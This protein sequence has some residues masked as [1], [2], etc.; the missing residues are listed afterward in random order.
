M[1]RARFVSLIGRESRF[2]AGLDGGAISSYSRDYDHPSRGASSLTLA[3]AEQS[4]LERQRAAY[5]DRIAPSISRHNA[6]LLRALFVHNLDQAEVAALQGCTRQ[7][8][9]QRLAILRRRFSKVNDWWRARLRAASPP[10]PRACV[11]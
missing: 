10:G 4:E 1:A 7:A 5:I 3:V 8:V 9:C 6:E 11:Q 2:R